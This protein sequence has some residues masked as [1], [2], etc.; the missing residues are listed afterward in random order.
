MSSMELGDRLIHVRSTVKH[1]K[2]FPSFTED[3]IVFIIGDI[4]RPVGLILNK[5]DP[6]ECFVLFPPATPM[7]D[8]IDLPENPTW[9]GA[10]IQLG[11]HKPKSAMLTIVSKLIQ[12]EELEEVQE[13][14]YIPIPPLVSEDHST[15]KK[16]GGPAAPKALTHDIKQMPTQEL[17]QLLSSLQQE[18]RTRHDAS[19]GSAH[20]VSS[21]LQTL[22]KEGALRTS[23]PRLSAFSG[24][25]AKGEVSFDQWSYELQ[26]LRKSY[27]DLALREGIQHSLRGAAAD[28]VCNMEPDV[29]LDLIIKKFTIIYGNVKSF[30][31]MM[32][33]FYRADQG[34]DES[35][36]SYATRIEGLLSQI[37]DKFP[38]QLPLQKEQRLLKD[39]LFHGSRKGIR[40][41]L[42]YCF[43]DASIDYMQFLE[44]C[45]KSEEEG[46]AGQ[47]R[48][49][50]KAKVKAAAATLTPNK[51]D[52]LSKQLKY[53]QHQ[54]D[55]FEGQ[56]KDLV[57]VVKATHTSSRGKN[58]N[59]CTYNGKGNPNKGNTSQQ[60]GQGQRGKDTVKSYQC[61]QCGEV[62]H[63]RRECPA[64][65]DKGLSPR[66][67]AGAAHRE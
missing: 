23:V 26:T 52:G 63:I 22:L 61:W 57:A 44:E 11:I 45:R 39:R 7:Q 17:Q 13:Y 31:L 25:V 8:V 40:D 60:R 32:R 47:A 14:V 19:M 67:N 42:K 29:P 36:P 59:S 3:D 30:D 56:V 2:D 48:A 65:K 6:L 46:K 24:D 4:V 43:A 62:G 33:D 16:K 12:G 58:G 34:E 51:D 50:V 66:G 18:M 64:L 21:V 37:R 38:D 54:I 27:S 55:A 41:S 10:S 20:D 15:L 28:V 53:Q 35:I 9:V 49:P 5:N 1:E